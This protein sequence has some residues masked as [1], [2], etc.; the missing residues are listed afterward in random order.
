[1]YGMNAMYMAGPTYID[2][3]MEFISV[4]TQNAGISTHIK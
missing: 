2:S 3:S 4:N 1:M